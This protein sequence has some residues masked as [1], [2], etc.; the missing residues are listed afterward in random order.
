MVGR[1]RSG[2]PKRIAVL[3]M[4]AGRLMGGE[5][6]D[7]ALPVVQAVGHRASESSSLC[8]QPAFR[9]QCWHGLAGLRASF[10]LQR[11]A[12]PHGRHVITQCI[13]QL[14]RVK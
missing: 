9:N 5:R 3:G 14:H 7:P 13:F 12:D 10:P 6:R 8:P 11:L 1:I 4:V 2:G